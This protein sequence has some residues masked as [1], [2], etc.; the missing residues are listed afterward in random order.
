MQWRTLWSPLKGSINMSWI[1]CHR[2]QRFVGK[3]TLVR[4]ILSHS[5]THSSFVSSIN[6]L[7]F[8][9]YFL[10]FSAVV[11]GIQQFHMIRSS[12]L[13][14]PYIFHLTHSVP[15][16]S[17]FQGNIYREFFHILSTCICGEWMVYSYLCSRYL[18][19]KSTDWI[20]VAP[21]RP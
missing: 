3:F 21:I 14:L 5:P 13:C 8:F 19:S 15:F 10:S 20:P 2:K 11:F 4:G 9:R 1:N 18:S 17:L 7:V 16:I 12:T 6:N